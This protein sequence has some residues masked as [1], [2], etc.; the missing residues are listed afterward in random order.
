MIEI[1]IKAVIAVAVSIYY[2]FRTKMYI[3]NRKNNNITGDVLI[4]W[5][6]VSL[7]DKYHIRERFLG[8]SK[9]RIKRDAKRHEIKY[10]W[11]SFIPAIFFIYYS[12]SAENIYLYAAAAINLLFIIK[13]L[14]DRIEKRKKLILLMGIVGY[15][16]SLAAFI[17]LSSGLFINDGVM[18]GFNRLSENMHDAVINA[19][20]IIPFALI[21]IVII[22]SI[23]RKRIISLIFGLL[24]VIATA[25]SVS[26]A[27]NIGTMN[28]LLIYY[29]GYVYISLIVMQLIYNVRALKKITFIH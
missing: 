14:F 19:G 12:I 10:Y 5:E 22:Y 8:G 3:E 17:V 4:R 1:I 18:P 29:T 15:I 9:L 11:I 26:A 21:M 23:I 7:I 25:I 13:V 28:F 6:S 24:T 27:D 20:V 16:V 2:V